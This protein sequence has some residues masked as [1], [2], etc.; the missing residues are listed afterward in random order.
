MFFDI[1]DANGNP[2][3]KLQK[4][5][6]TGGGIG[7]CCRMCCEFSNYILE[8]PPDSTTE[9]RMLLLGGLFQIDYVYFEKEG[10]DN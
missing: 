4:T 2:V 6:G 7:A 5:F 3:A 10:G 9:Q 8:F 1:L